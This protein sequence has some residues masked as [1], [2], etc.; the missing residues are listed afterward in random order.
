MATRKEIGAMMAILTAAYPALAISRQTMEV[1]SQELADVP[2]E[3]LI[4]AAREH[5]RRSKWFPTIAE[6]REEYDAY[7]QKQAR[8]AK[9]RQWKA[10]L[11]NWKHEALP[12]GEARKMLS[13]VIGAANTARKGTEIVPF[14]GRGMKRVLAEEAK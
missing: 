8:D 9:E 2:P 12:G 13:S 3:F 6:L 5:V 14:R 4:N 1:Y 10:N 7:S 11:E